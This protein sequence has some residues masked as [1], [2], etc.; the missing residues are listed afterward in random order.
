VYTPPS[1]FSAG[2]RSP[3]A[4]APFPVVCAL[5]LA[6]STL[7]PQQG[8][9]LGQTPSGWARGTAAFLTRR[10]GPEQQPRTLTSS[11]CRPGI[12]LAAKSSQHCHWVAHCLARPTVTRRLRLSASQGSPPQTWPGRLPRPQGHVTSE[13]PGTQARTR[14]WTTLPTRPSATA[15]TRPAISLS[16]LWTWQSCTLLQVAVHVLEQ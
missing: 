13:Q 16:Q 7:T 14:T 6:C 1:F 5:H 10:S 12:P 4:C 9:S 15:A 3:F 8:F 2:V 11:P